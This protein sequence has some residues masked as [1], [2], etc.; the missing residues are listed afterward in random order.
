M[1]RGTPFLWAAPMLAGLM[2][3]CPKPQPE[4]LGPEPELR[5]G[6]AVGSASVRLGGD[7]ELFITD[8]GNGAAVGA[9]R[10]GTAW[11]V[12]PDSGGG[13]VLLRP[14]GSRTERHGGIS[15]VNVTEGRFA[16]ANG[17]RFRGGSTWCVPRGADADQPCAGE[18]PRGRGPRAGAP[19]AGGAQRCSR[20]Q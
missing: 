17:R 5:V 13:L 16:M 11:A 18:L 1:Q 20:R 10:A 6:L 14:D 12:V 7:G 2:A 3:G 19:A 4:V 15:A 9:I 8:D